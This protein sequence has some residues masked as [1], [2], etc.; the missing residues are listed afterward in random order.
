MPH[1]RKKAVAYHQ[2]LVVLDAIFRFGYPATAKYLAHLR[3]LPFEMTCRALSVL[4][5]EGAKA[6]SVWRGAYGL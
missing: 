2:Q 5:A 1:R 4:K 3:G 6:M